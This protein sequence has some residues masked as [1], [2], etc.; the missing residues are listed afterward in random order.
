L[1]QSL[2]STI[3]CCAAILIGT[4]GAATARAEPLF[5]ADSYPATIDGGAKGILTTV[6]RFGAAWECLSAT[7]K[8]EL[9]EA[10][11]ALTISPVYEECRWNYPV[12]N[13][14]VWS[15]VKV[16]M[17]G[18]DFRFHSL[19]RLA[20]DEYESLFDL[21]CS[22]GNQMV[23]ELNSGPW[24]A[25]RLTVPAQSN[26]ALVGFIDNTK[27]VFDD[28]GV[29]FSVK[30][31]KFTQDV[32]GFPVACP[33]KPGTYEFFEIGGEVNTFTATAEGGEQTGFRVIGE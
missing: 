9:T 3:L 29:V 25:C 7:Y 23:V 2:Y 5:E 32:S 6:F 13:P 11:S 8:G 14:Q 33:V 15:T 27:G 1:K 19:E 20:A 4:A 24:L 26:K 28:V 18:C 16:S 30:G 21:Q 12:T 10:A 22:S 17:N 31:M